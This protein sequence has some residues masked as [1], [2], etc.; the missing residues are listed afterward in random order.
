MDRLPPLNSLRMFE[1]TA[2]LLSMHKAAAALHVTP[3]AVSKQIQSLESF[4]AI[5]LFNRNK[6][7]LELTRAGE[8]Y[9]AHISTALSSIRHATRE[10]SGLSGDTTLKIRSYTTFSMY[11]LIPR[12]SSFH[13]LHPDINIDLTTSIQW[14]DFD[15]ENVDAAI[16]LGDGNWPGYVAIP[17]VP[18]ILVAVCSPELARTLHDVADLRHTTLLHTKARPDDWQHWLS[19]VGYEA[20]EDLAQRN[21]ESSVLVYQAATRGQGVAMA[22]KALVQ[23]LVESGELVYPFP[24]ELDMSA[25]TY[26][27]VMPENRPAPHQLTIF[28]DWLINSAEWGE[29]QPA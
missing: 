14:T 21:Y 10:I 22:Q 19:S 25:Y 2:K 8:K 3:A 13:A 5:K 11:W 20:V 9:Y 27:F 15:A 12:L 17:L 24:Q 29:Q 7:G 16:R 28:K 4:L 18:N 1:T 6:R 26:Y 23:P